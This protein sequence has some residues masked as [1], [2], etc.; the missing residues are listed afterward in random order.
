MDAALTPRVRMMVICD[1]VRESKSEE[2]VY[3]IKGLRQSLAAPTFPFTPKRFWTFLLLS[4]PRGGEY[5]CYVRIV[6]QR[7]DKL[8]RFCHIEP[9]PRFGAEGGV[10]A[11]YAPISCTFPEPGSYAVELWFFQEQGSDVLKGETPFLI[12]SESE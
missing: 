1:G 7:T 12:N 6:N 5:P 4:S 2:G 3:H 8:V 10:W 9:R 11:Y